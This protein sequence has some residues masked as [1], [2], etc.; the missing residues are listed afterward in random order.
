MTLPPAFTSNPTEYLHHFLP[1]D[2][3]APYG[4]LTTPDSFSSAPLIA[5][6]TGGVEQYT[7]TVDITDTATGQQFASCWGPDGQRV[8]YQHPHTRVLS[9]TAPVE[10]WYDFLAVK[11]AQARR[12]AAQQ[13]MPWD[14]DGVEQQLYRIEHDVVT[15]GE[16]SANTANF[17]NNREFTHWITAAVGASPLN[18]LVLSITDLQQFPQDTKDALMCLKYKRGEHDGSTLGSTIANS[19]SLLAP[20]PASPHDLGDDIPCDNDVTLTMDGSDVE[21]F[22]GDFMTFYSWVQDCV[23]DHDD[24]P[25]WYVIIP[26]QANVALPV[27]SQGAVVTVHHDGDGSQVRVNVTCQ[28]HAA[29]R[30]ELEDGYHRRWGAWLD[31]EH[32]LAEDVMETAV[33]NVEAALRERRE[34]EAAGEVTYGRAH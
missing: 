7:L 9:D 23:A 4:T 15:F 19:V 11:D 25:D 3:L 26:V 21:Y 18:F 27:P 31:E 10:D 20:D 29:R 34:Q 28:D 17:A 14:G 16:E 33:H 2:Y 13:P 8:K 22:H 5:N 24:R 32:P 12:A 6:D 1:A 30:N